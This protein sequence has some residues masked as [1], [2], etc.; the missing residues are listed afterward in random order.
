[1]KSLPLQVLRRAAV[2]PL[3]R[4][5]GAG[6][7]AR[8]CI[9]VDAGDGAGDRRSRRAGASAGQAQA[10]GRQ[11][12]RAQGDAV[13]QR[14]RRAQPP[15]GRARGEDGAAGRPA[16]GIAGGARGRPSQPT[17]ALPGR[18][19]PVPLAHDDAGR[20]ARPG[21]ADARRR[22]CSPAGAGRAIA[23]IADADRHAGPREPAPLPRQAQA[24]PPTPTPVQ[25]PSATAPAPPI[26]TSGGAPG[27]PF[28]QSQ[29][30]PPQQPTLTLEVQKGTAIKLPGAAATVFVASPDIADVQVKSPTM[31]YV[32]AKKPGETVL[33]AVDDQDRVLL[34]TI[35]SVT[36]PISRMKAQLDA[37]HP[38]NGIQFDNQGETIVLSGVARS[39]VDADDAR[40]IALAQVNNSP[41]QGHQQHPG[42]GTQP[43]A[44]QGQGGRGASRGAEAHRRQLAEYR[45]RLGG[46]RAARRDGGQRRLR[47]RHAAVDRRRAVG[48]RAH[49]RRQLRRPDRLPRHPEPGDCAGRAQSRRHVRRDGELPGRRRDPGDRAAGRHP[50]WAASR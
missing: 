27:R 15:R 6:G 19:Q 23:R 46:H 4:R 40:R 50:H 2:A 37:L 22:H 44:A 41:Q 7:V 20:S 25:P 12:A 31:I 1:M 48:D 18:G 11:E 34:N 21:C 39:A 17:A 38:G 8:L 36:S 24:R 16:D 26:V 14:R 5:A 29:I 33:Y 49:H 47:R 42:R 30:V 9:P 32:F 10:Q 13:R 3:R 35:V 45:Q 43:G 28:A